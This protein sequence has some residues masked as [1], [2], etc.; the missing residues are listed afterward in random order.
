MDNSKSRWSRKPVDVTR[1]Q[2]KTA[3]QS[4]PLGYAQGLSKMEAVEMLS[5]SRFL[6]DVKDF[7]YQRDGSIFSSDEEAIEKFWSDRTWRNSNVMMTG[8]D[9]IASQGYSTEQKERLGRIQMVFDSN[10]HF[11]EDGGRGAEGFWAN[12][13]AMLLDPVNLIGFGLG[14]AGAKAAAKAATMAGRK[15]T[16]MELAKAGAKRGAVSEAVASGVIEAGADALVQNRDMSVG[17]QD[18][19]SLGRTAMAGGI[20]AT[21]GGAI[22]GVLGGVAPAVGRKASEITGIDKLD[23]I[24]SGEA[25]GRVELQ[26]IE[27][28]KA[29]EAAE[30]ADAQRDLEGLFGEYD[31]QLRKQAANNQEQLAGT[32]LSPNLQTAI[33]AG[34]GRYRTPEE[35]A[36]AV[37]VELNSPDFDQ[38]KQVYDQL[39]LRT[40]HQRM[41]NVPAEVA[42]LRSQAERTQV[43]AARGDAAAD[44]VKTDENITNAQGLFDRANRLEAAY[45]RY[46]NWLRSG[47]FR[48]DDIPPPD[49]QSAVDEVAGLLGREPQTGV[50]P[51]N[52]RDRGEGFTVRDEADADAVQQQRAARGLDDPTL[53]PDRQITEAPPGPRNV[54]GEGFETVVD[55]SEAAQ[56]TAPRTAAEAE[57]SNAK[58]M[59]DNALA[60]RDE[61]H[62]AIKN[63]Q[64]KARR[65]TI[66]E[67]ETAELS[68]LIKTRAQL[69]KDVK[70]AGAR[71]TAAENALSRMANDVVDD[72]TNTP[73]Q[74]AEEGAEVQLAEAAEEV[75]EPEAPPAV[76]RTLEDGAVETAK[77]EGETL[78]FL[79]ALGFDK[80]QMRR[81]VRA[82]TSG[83]TR[84]EARV[85]RAQFAT[86]KVKRLH[87]ASYVQQ[88]IDMMGGVDKPEVY[89]MGAMR[90][91]I[92]SLDM[93]PGVEELALD[94]YNDFVIDNAP[95]IL[96]QVVEGIGLGRSVDDY[97]DFIRANYGD[98]LV[99]VLHRHM[100]GELDTLDRI[101]TSRIELPKLDDFTPS[102]RKALQEAMKILEAD[103]RS[104]GWN[105]AAIQM[106][107][108]QFIANLKQKKADGINPFRDGAHEGRS[109]ESFGTITVNGKEYS[110]HRL[111][112]TQSIISPAKKGKGDYKYYGKL[113]SALRRDGV[114][115]T[116][117]EAAYRASDEAKLENAT[118]AMRRDP[119][120]YNKKT[121]D[122]ETVHEGINAEAVQ[123]IDQAR[124]VL[125]GIDPT[126]D[127][128]EI[129]AM[130]VEEGIIPSVELAKASF[131]PQEIELGD[132]IAI[133]GQ[134]PKNVTGYKALSGS[135]RTDG[136]VFV[137]RRAVPLTGEAL[138]RTTAGKVRLDGPRVGRA[139]IKVITAQ[140]IK[141]MP[142]H[143]VIDGI[144]YERVLASPGKET[145][146]PSGFNA[147]SGGDKVFADPNT[148]R[149]FARAEDV[150]ENQR[151]TTV[152]DLVEDLLAQRKLLTQS[153]DL[154]IKARD[155]ENFRGS[156]KAQ[157]EV[158]YRE[159]RNASRELQRMKD[160]KA[161]PVQILAMERAV[162][163]KKKELKTDYPEMW[164]DR[165]VIKKGLV[166]LELAK[167]AGKIEDMNKEVADLADEA[168]DTPT[169][170]DKAVAKVAADKA[171]QQYAD[172]NKVSLA[173]QDAVARFQEHGD[174]RRLDEELAQI[175]AE[176]A[177]VSHEKPKTKPRA[178]RMPMVVK[179]RGVEVD[180]ENH[181]SFTGTE[182]EGFD[183]GFLG[184]KIGRIEKTDEGFEVISDDLDA[185]PVYDSFDLAKR[186]LVE[187]FEP[188]IKVAFR[189]GKLMAADAPEEVSFHEPNH[190]NTNTYKGAKQVDAADEEDIA[191][192]FLGTDE[193]L[194]QSGADYAS[195][196]PA[197]RKF[198]VGIKTGPF[199][200]IAR[201]ASTDD[202]L[203]GTILSKQSEQ[204]FVLGHTQEGT[205]GTKASNS[206]IPFD[207]EDSFEPASKGQP[208][209]ARKPRKNELLEQDP[210]LEDPAK[211][212]VSLNKTRTMNLDQE[213][214]PADLQGRFQ[215]VYD[216]HDEIVN[217]ERLPWNS[218]QFASKQ[219]YQRFV[220]HLRTLNGILDQYAPHGIKLPNASR[221]AS[222]RQLTAVMGERPVG[223]INAVI[224]VLRNLSEGDS[225]MPRF[226][227]D[228]NGYSHRPANYANT[229]ELN[230]ISVAE[231]LSP[232]V[233]PGFAKTIHEIG[234]WA[235]FNVLT[236]A[237][238]TTFWDAMGKYITADGVDMGMLKKRLPEIGGNELRSPQE[239][240]AQQFTQF[241][242]SQKR[243]GET[244]ALMK[245]W[246]RVAEKVQKIMRAFFIEDADAIDADLMPIFERILP[247]DDSSVN[248]FMQVAKKYSEAGP[249][250]GYP[251][252][253]LA[254]FEDIRL[255]IERAIDTGNEDAIEDALR[256]FVREVYAYSGKPGN[257]T[258]TNRNTG[259]KITRV[260]LFDAR[261]IGEAADG[262]KKHDFVNSHF[263]RQNLV[264]RMYAIQRHLAENPKKVLSEEDRLNEIDKLIAAQN[265]DD[266]GELNKASMTSTVME[267][268]AA[269]A[270]DASEG[271]VL[272]ANDVLGSINE[273]QVE[274]RRRIARSVGK[275]DTG[276][277]VKI[278]P[279][280]KEVATQDSARGNKFRKRAQKRKQA[281]AENAEQSV[282]DTL[283]KMEA[284]IS[285]MPSK[286]SAPESGAETPSLKGESVMGLMKRYKKTKASSPEKREIAQEIAN[287]M[288]A[289]PELTPLEKLSMEFQT[290]F[291]DRFK[292][293][294][295]SLHEAIV[296]MQRA[297]DEG[298]LKKAHEYQSFIGAVHGTVEMPSL[299]RSVHKAVDTEMHQNVGSQTE[300]GIPSSAPQ[301]VK[302]ALGLITHRDKR[303]E[304]TGRTILYRVLNLM[305]KTEKDLV[306]QTEF[307][308]FA[309][310]Q[311]IIGNV[312]SEAPKGSKT[313]M[314]VMDKSYGTYLGMEGAN[315]NSALMNALR[316]HFRK[317]GTNVSKPGAP[318]RIV[319]S[320]AQNANTSTQIRTAL[321]EVGHMLVRTKFDE[322]KMRQLRRFLDDKLDAGDETAAS[323]VQNYGPEAA[324]EEYFVDEFAKW[325]AGR[326][327]AKD[328]FGEATLQN[329]MMR[330]INEL[331]EMIA[332][333]L[334]GMVRNKTM[335]QEFR[336]LTGYGD[337]FRVRKRVQK[338]TSQAV[339]STDSYAMPASLAPRYAQETVANMSDGQRIAARE[340]VGAREGE[341]LMDFVYYHGT[342]NGKAFSRAENP[343]V[344]LEPSGN[345][346]LYGPGIYVTKKQ[347][348]AEDY[349]V[350][351]HRASFERMINEA[352]DDPAK[353][354]EGAE[355][356]GMLI[357]VR[358]EI[359]TIQREMEGTQYSQQTLDR[360]K[361]IT[362]GELEDYSTDGFDYQLS[363]Y[364]RRLTEKVAE[365]DALWEA[366]ERATGATR[367]PA[368]LPLLVRAD[369]TFNMDANTFYRFGEGTN[370]I[371]W[372]I[373]EMAKRGVI[374]TDGAMKVMQRIGTRDFSG[375]DLYEALIE[376]V[377]EQGISE[378]DAKA[379][380]NGFIKDLG[381]DSM[382]ITEVNPNSQDMIEALVLFE[383]TQVKHVDAQTFDYENPE[384]YQLRLGDNGFLGE[385]GEAIIDNPD[386]D[387]P[388]M[389]ASILNAAERMGAPK[390]V[391]EFIN[392]TTRGEDLT[393]SDI[394]GVS[395]AYKGNLL[396]ENS[397][398]FRKN[399]AAWIGN[400]LKPSN[401]VGLF[402][403]HNAD[404][405]KR[406]Q[407]AL[408]ALRSV[409]DY[410]NSARRFFEKSKGLA[411]PLMKS[412][413]QAS[414]PASHD[415]IMRALRQDDLSSLSTG[416]RAIAQQL[417]DVFAQELVDLR[418]AGYNVGDVLRLGKKYY[419]PQAW[420]TGMIRDNPRR[421][422]N[423]MTD[424][425]IK[426]RRQAGM[427]ADRAEAELAAKAMMERMLDTDGRIDTDPIL[428]KKMQSDPFYQR[429]INLDPEEIPEFEE[430]LVNDLEG[431]VTRYF[432]KTT[433]KLILAREFGVQGHGFMSYRAVAEGGLDAAIR[434]LQTSKI[435]KSVRRDMEVE[436]EV[437]DVVIPPLRKS[438]DE[439]RS[440]LSQVQQMVGGTSAQKAAQKSA[441]IDYLFNHGE[442]TSMDVAMRNNWRKRVE[443]IV[444]AMADFPMPA[445]ARLLKQMD[446]MFNAINK[447]PIDGGD[448]TELVDNVSR[449][450]R[451]FNAVTLLGWTTLTSAP[452]AVL[453]LIRSGNFTAWAKGMRQI[454]QKD[455]SYRQAA[456]DI[457]VGI[458]N[459]IHDRMTHMAGEGSQRFT[460]AFFNATLLTPWTNF[461]REASAIVGFNAMKAEADTARRLAQQGKFGTR[462]KTAV[463]FLARYG[464]E[465]Y[466]DPQGPQLM[467]V[468]QHVRDDKIR[469]AI[470]RFTSETIFTPDPNDIPLWAQTPVGKIVF[471][472]KSFPVMMQ[473]MVFGEGGV[474]SEAFGKNP[475]GTY[476]GNF[477][478]LLALVTAGSA[479]GGGSLALKDLA[480]SRGGKDDRSREL[481][482]RKI[483]DTIFA[484]IAQAMGVDPKDYAGRPDEL[485]GWW[486]EGIVAVGGL[487]FLAELM[488]NSAEQLDNGAYGAT[489]I[490]SGIL[491]PGVG[492]FMDVINVGAGIEQ[493]LLGDGESAGKQ[494][495]AARTIAGRVPVL[496]GMRSFREG[497]ADLMGDP[498]STNKNGPK[499]KDPLAKFRKEI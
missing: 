369:E 312:A 213:D 328:A 345:Q 222:M 153:T 229:A 291:S 365:E 45:D 215:T 171:S 169:P 2:A 290:E 196:V 496:G 484:D 444:N 101:E 105:K 247:E 138:K 481:R 456:R 140:G 424:R 383:P 451:G 414:Q 255:E 88:A 343:D 440:I 57:L 323:F 270:E 135:K 54:S 385:L 382:R 302:N 179:H 18:E 494:R 83:V 320:G 307:L 425:F 448:G 102:E 209:K 84:A 330:I 364:Q 442:L 313:A 122:G 306:N 351:G 280:G 329:G 26:K 59:Y 210:D 17:I 314:S 29:A 386:V 71:V 388:Q 395:N 197:G 475:D 439:I 133:K 120:K 418:A 459:L 176:A 62:R 142:N 325:M 284:A 297:M 339:A 143:E 434:V 132:P 20:G 12:A 118:N 116:G 441:A 332:Y 402:Q 401:G 224:S 390:A 299:L 201:T 43:N 76:E 107:A 449:K 353:R 483:S 90:S 477:G 375:E 298:N 309:E 410:G 94:V 110:G 7:Y 242:I 374:P 136:S 468:T 288:A 160:A 44:P 81:E 252:Q 319:A 119:V 341:D 474:M 498:R 380:I 279:E 214:L 362:S 361:R 433:R 445:H 350:I 41:R 292:K 113:I 60:K 372:L 124:K 1:Y 493:G 111:G 415:R 482:N 46:S 259:K 3:K 112:K 260:R 220:M 188:R 104:Q 263:V 243:A 244:T 190:Q 48:N 146:T 228:P 216:L 311:N 392:K 9:A 218:P 141:E 317:L 189:E 272:L 8:I 266:F 305:G 438:D 403:K 72:V 19:Y 326:V 99:E 452:D 275:T 152:E 283:A 399:G 69:R 366:L 202:K 198:A 168:G 349:S 236:P 422:L 431:L 293:E 296:G 453:P 38:V 174:T 367:K 61:A 162:Q 183:L 416:E 354:A 478:P 184:Q 278:T 437:E 356:S 115:M 165:K 193:R 423:L 254:V 237:E 455:P 63:L 377:R 147:F 15:A 347:G 191:E 240:F 393:P 396:G 404:L 495:Q 11:W 58:E 172:A 342:P 186:G 39:K 253:K 446:K 378:N 470:M 55:T 274:L 321:H 227:Q 219:D 6:Q 148:N 23:F 466:G 4:G 334:N 173:Y 324:A 49:V 371:N 134:Y 419:L 164:K 476:K 74:M 427:S 467:D 139:K 479:F 128:T 80:K 327:S 338:P 178:K 108:N 27:M 315:K 348:V 267:A 486:L 285:G 70:Q 98:E 465:D 238:R 21:V 300:N 271:L 131:R 250:V 187:D 256:G 221:H 68:D 461:M 246:T 103:G 185:T 167:N 42:N 376:G 100:R 33:D 408:T 458:E 67:D 211:Q 154:E 157:F 5:D 490:A 251:A 488:Y 429:M 357:N 82:L 177:K 407:P 257:K 391:R 64:A 182:D 65:G 384:I 32:A 97:F 443:G 22:G 276:A 159:Y 308:T 151:G 13:G 40:E 333:V 264:Q 232:D 435:V 359:N 310:L 205:S 125:K 96:N 286:M 258:I 426:D 370:S 344:V 318:L 287:R 106:F 87:A 261:Q 195:Q 206:F 485:I 92:K 37:G 358:E 203:V 489:R 462:Y 56:T 421:F 411:A 398:F 450:V 497:A 14:G 428:N 262:T 126:E 163:A 282:Q 281:V 192:T 368:V 409:P 127:A 430:F 166:E 381:Y 405:A 363:Q 245:L 413:R 273:A 130:L 460:N 204:E 454:M 249:R 36:E 170:E 75:L 47:A 129:R 51:A 406:L 52:P 387:I 301:A 217:L 335:R 337:M 352:T 155:V 25:E 289:I 156:D 471:Q 480:Q 360:A 150:P 457:G 79:E 277:G 34:S 50:V 85:I 24:K 389:R 30:A 78:S 412:A 304:Y 199:A 66:G 373:D 491:G 230:S 432:D 239:F 379:E 394:E 355:I 114:T 473:R 181:F 16:G 207:P 447:R 231:D 149:L 86:E 322:P 223:E 346:S 316:K 397:A 469:Y 121:V 73:A 28:Q 31:E 436:A 91:I 499:P 234:H 53:G 241:A 340:F 265:A 35:F 472:L 158:K 123:K 336:N 248:K 233:I 93:E 331:K 463:R 109:V 137:L 89:I 417:A 144:L 420:D 294:T 269:V 492:N 175:K 180:L 145:E 400:I 487:G 226:I 117:R 464:L 212:P 268:T 235:Y 200:G 208:K 77:T 10:P 225:R 295:M 95:S 194:N 303:V 161:K